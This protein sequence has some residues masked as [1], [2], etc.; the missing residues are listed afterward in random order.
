MKLGKSILKVGYTDDLNKRMYQYFSTNP[1]FDVLGIREGDE[2]LEDMIQIY[3][4][5]LGYQQ[6]IGGRLN[7]WFE[8]DPEVQQIFHISQDRLERML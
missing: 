3:L 1:G 8:D 6:K 7:E 4:T 2:I 5:Y